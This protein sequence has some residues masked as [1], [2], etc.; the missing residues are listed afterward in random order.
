[1][2]S[3]ATNQPKPTAELGYMC[4]PRGLSD[5]PAV[6]LTKQLKYKET[7]TKMYTPCKHTYILWSILF[8]YKLR[9]KINHNI[10]TYS[11]GPWC[12]FQVIDSYIICK[13]TPPLRLNHYLKR[14]IKTFCGK[15]FVDKTF[16][17]NLVN[18][19]FFTMLFETLTPPQ[20][21]SHLR[22][23]FVLML[24]PFIPELAMSKDRL[25]IEHPSVLLFSLQL[26]GL[27]QN[28]LM[29]KGLDC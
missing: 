2:F 25:S 12:T 16:L 13:W 27:F 20:T 7:S 6:T 26:T 18:S 11:T 15:W 23:T 29:T 9:F 1:M 22:L 24:T 28:R 10:I 8:L 14:N 21:W 17:M 5:P 3:N 19:W 4:S